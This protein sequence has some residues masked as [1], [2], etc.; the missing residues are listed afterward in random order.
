MLLIG[1]TTCLH[2]GEDLNFVEEDDRR[3]GDE[4]FLEDVAGR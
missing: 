4:V 3:E 2:V 1:I